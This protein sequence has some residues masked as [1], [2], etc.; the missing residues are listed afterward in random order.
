MESSNNIENK[1][2]Y[3]K[4]KLNRIMQLF[5]MERETAQKFLK[6]INEEKNNNINVLDSNLKN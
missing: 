4:E 6:L 5:G 3:N 2:I 1:N